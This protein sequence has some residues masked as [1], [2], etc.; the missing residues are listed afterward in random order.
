MTRKTDNPAP[1]R[2]TKVPGRRLWAAM[3]ADYDFDEHELVLLR[4]ATR[5]VD[6]LDALAAIVEREGLMVAGPSGDRVHP[7]LVEAR[8]LKIALAR[9]LAALRLPAGE[10]GDHQAGSRRPQRRVGA[11]G[12]YGIR[13]G[14]SA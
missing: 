3:L 11:R 4:E 12:V 5:T 10:A 7:A 8:Q 1:P 13:G 9:L 14:G 6:L 2:G